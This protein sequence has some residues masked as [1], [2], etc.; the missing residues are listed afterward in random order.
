LWLG[1][2]VLGTWGPGAA[3]E[4][5]LAAAKA[6]AL[7]ALESA[8]QDKDERRKATAKVWFDAASS[9][10]WCWLNTHSFMLMLLNTQSV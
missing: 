5:D 7:E 3:S 1:L 6:A 10:Q 4:G 2:D 9:R 8:C